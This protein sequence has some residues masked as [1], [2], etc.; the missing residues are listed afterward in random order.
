M[1][2][3]SG[4]KGLRNKLAVENSGS[5]EN[6]NQDSFDNWF[7]ELDF[8]LYGIIN[9][10]PFNVLLF[11]FRFELKTAT[12]IVTHNSLQHVTV[13]V[14]QFDSS[15]TILPICPIVMRAAQKTNLTSRQISFQ[16]LTVGLVKN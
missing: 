2:F 7:L 11:R 15:A 14:N 16:N 1:G 12:Y 13:L 4:F 9:F 10:T 8:I 5:T 6:N 3:N